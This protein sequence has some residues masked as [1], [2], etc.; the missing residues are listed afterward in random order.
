M[1]ELDSGVYNRDSHRRAAAGRAVVAR[2]DVP[3][4]RSSGGSRTGR[5]RRPR[6][7]FG[8]T[9]RAPRVD[10]A[11]LQPRQRR[12]PKTRSRRGHACRWQPTGRPGAAPAAVPRAAR[13]HRATR[14]TTQVWAGPGLGP[15]GSTAAVAADIVAPAKVMVAARIAAQ[16]VAQ[17]RWLVHIAY[18]SVSRGSRPDV[19]NHNRRES[20]YPRSKS[21]PKFRSMT[22]ARFVKPFPRRACDPAVPEVPLIRDASERL[23]DRTNDGILTTT[24][25]HCARS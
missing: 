11:R 14:V 21:S 17:D 6:E 15:I 9:Q 25:R 20:H 7:A 16:R 1:I 2:A 24:E 12:C 13:R 18:P 10:H 22:A 3:P 8:P 4:T 23:R 5:S 19:R